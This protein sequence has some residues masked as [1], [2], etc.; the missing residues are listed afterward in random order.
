[1]KIS[2][3]LSVII[4]CSLFIFFILNLTHSNVNSVVQTDQ[5]EIK[6]PKGAKIYKVKC[7]VCHQA[8]GEG[9]PGVFPPL[10]NSDYLFA[11]KVRAVN[12][13]LNGSEVEMVVNG[14]TYTTPMPPQVDTKDDAI[15]VVNY[16]L[17]AWENNG[18]IV[19]QE[20]VKNI[21]I[22]PR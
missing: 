12:Q 16:I 6:Y 5:A 15:E 10:K 7:V 21:K 1:M 17:N 4:F 3:N 9:I 20:D 19:S 22:N 2:R 13:V 8:S 18:G 11:D 14:I